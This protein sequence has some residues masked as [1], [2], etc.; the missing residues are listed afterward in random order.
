MTLGQQV[1]LEEAISMLELFS[2]RGYDELDSAYVYNEGETERILGAAFDRIGREQ[3]KVATKVNPRITGRLDGEAAKSQLTES[4][5]RMGL[6]KAD[7]FYLH[8]PDPLT[9]LRACSARD[10]MYRA[11]KFV[12]LGLSNFSPGW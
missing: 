12:E 11:G 10:E 4:L 3:F 1:F 2:S 7:I 9:R 6:T 5:E 8:F